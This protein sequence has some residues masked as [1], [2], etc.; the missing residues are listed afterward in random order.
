MCLCFDGAVVVLLLLLCC[1][2]VLRCVWLCDSPANLYATEKPEWDKSRLVAYTGLSRTAWGAG[3]AAL[4]VLWFSAPHNWI[5]RFL[6]A[7]YWYVTSRTC[8]LP[9]MRRE[10]VLQERARRGLDGNE[11]AERGAC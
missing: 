11:G 4:C 5:S 6:S 7:R 8:R 10:H 1:C 9:T 2:C 3:L